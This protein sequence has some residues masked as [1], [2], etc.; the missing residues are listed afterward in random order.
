MMSQG[1]STQQRSN[2]SAFALTDSGL[3]ALGRAAR[4]NAFKVAAIQ[5]ASGPNVAGNLS[6]ARRLI[7][8]AAEQGARLVVLPEFFAIMGMTDQDKV[9]V[10][11]QLGQGP[12]QSLLSEPPRQYKIWL[13]GGSIPLAA[14]TPDK[15]RNTCL[16]FDEQG[17]QVAR[18]DKRSE[19]HTSELQ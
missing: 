12:I 10:R 17:E 7:A 13:V 11:E 15:V 18:Y 4:V 9:A 3:P 8:K 5:M 2:N 1:N 16:V 6:E 19:E 14:S